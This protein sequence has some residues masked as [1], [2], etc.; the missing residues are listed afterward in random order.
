MASLQELY[1]ATK[2]YAK[3]NYNLEYL[4]GI[5]EFIHSHTR[6]P[7][8]FTE[9][10]D[11]IK[12]NKSY[13]LAFISACINVKGSLC[14]SEEKFDCTLKV[15]NHVLD[16]IQNSPFMTIQPTIIHN[17]YV[18]WLDTDCIDFS[19]IMADYD[20]SML[21]TINMIIKKIENKDVKEFKYTKT[22]ENAVAPYKTRHTDSGFDL[23]IVEKIKNIGNVFYYDTG[24][25]VEPPMGYYFDLVPRSSLSKTGW[26]LANNIGIIDMSYRGTIIVAL[27]KHDKNADDLQLP[28]RAVQLIPRRV[29]QFTPKEVTCLNETN[30]NDRGFGNGSQ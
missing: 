18:S 1:V 8:N 3:S 17:N 14:L 30:R 29:E 26:T 13:T 20:N 12:N 22:H 15:N 19:R 7:V 9:M 25:A 24:I 28:F 16:I 2:K 11:I 5:L 21:N 10:M 23:H 6:Y 27:Y 4:E